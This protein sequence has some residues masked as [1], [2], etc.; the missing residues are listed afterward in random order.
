MYVKE[1]FG[2]Y[3]QKTRKKLSSFHCESLSGVALLA[4]Y[5][6]SKDLKVSK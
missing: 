2:L 5:A 3:G 6:A 1:G 4:S